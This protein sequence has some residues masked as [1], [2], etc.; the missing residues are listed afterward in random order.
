VLFVAVVT[1]AAGIAAMVIRRIARAE[2]A[3]SREKRR[4]EV[5]LHSIGDGVITTDADGNILYL[6]PVA[7]ELTG[8]SLQEAHARPLQ[9]IYRIH[10]ERTREPVEHPVIS[11][12]LDG[13]VVGLD[14]HSILINR[15]GDEYA[16]EDTAAPIRNSAGDVA[17]SV[18]VFRDVTESRTLAEELRW[19]ACHDALTGLTNRTEFEYQLQQMI[20]S[21]RSE[22]KPHALLYLDLD[23]FKVVNDTCG[24][25]AGDVLLKQ[26]AQVMAP[27]VR[28]TDVLARLGGDEFGVLLESCPIEQAEKIA[29]GLREAIHSYRFVWQDKT[30]AVAASIGVVGISESTADATTLMSGAD[31]ACYVRLGGGQEAGRDAVGIASAQCPRR[32]P[33]SSFLAGDCARGHTECDARALRDPDQDD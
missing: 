26:I 19:Q 16:V 30:F 7:E 13:S 8:W 1:L 29:N 2:Q 10:H 18:L 20:A 21:A 32:R 22:H 25:M 28:D 11:G 27:L 6:N 15:A 24:H 17:G 9:D 14:R 23:Q 4:A 33:L 31:A 12:G 3:L 5:T